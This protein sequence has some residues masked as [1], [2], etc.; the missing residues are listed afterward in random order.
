MCVYSQTEV[1][2][3][4]EEDEFE[5]DTEGSVDVEFYEEGEITPSQDTEEMSDPHS[6][7]FRPDGLLMT[8][9]DE[10]SFEGYL[11]IKVRACLSVWF[12]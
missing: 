5:F 9:D 4:T 12:V 1:E 7:K 3:D 8:Y 10:P 11:Q 2:S 6:S